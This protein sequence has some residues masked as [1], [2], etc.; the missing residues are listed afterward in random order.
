[1]DITKEWW[2][3]FNPDKDPTVKA[4]QVQQFFVDKGLS[5]DTNTAY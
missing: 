4:I 5:F 2:I 3:S 1:M